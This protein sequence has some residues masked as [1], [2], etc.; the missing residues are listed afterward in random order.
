MMFKAVLTAALLLTAL[1]ALACSCVY[2]SGTQSDHVRREFQ[3]AETVFS[4]YVHSI[5]Y[6]DVAGHRTRMARLRVLQVWKG[7]LQPN[8]W[9]D[10]I[11][12][13]ESG[14]VGC[15][16]ATEPDRALMIYAAGQRP[17]RLASC[18]LTGPL[19]RATG[20]IPLL[21]RLS[22]RKRAP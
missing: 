1:P 2:P 4:G 21:N 17:Y 8:T 20:D 7:D 9:I 16:Y 22:T 6:L 5:H 10:V 14:L 13:D 15:G 18:S 3:G 11:S 19:E 12:D